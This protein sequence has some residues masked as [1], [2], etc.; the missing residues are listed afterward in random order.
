M[1][2]IAMTLLSTVRVSPNQVSSD[3]DGESVILDLASGK[4]YGLDEVGAFIWK[5]M[6]TPIQVQALRDAL[7]AEYDVTPEDC[8][9]DVLDLLQQLQTAGLVEVM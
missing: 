9:Q 8:A 3:L 4:Y 5:L 6:Q 2:Q 7:L 1:A